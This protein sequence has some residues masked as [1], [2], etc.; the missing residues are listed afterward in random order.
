MPDQLQPP[1][2]G[3]AGP[4]NRSPLPGI[5][6]D[7]ITVDIETFGS[8]DEAHLRSD[9]VRE[10]LAALD[11]DDEEN[12][13]ALVRPLHVAD[14]ADLIEL[15]SNERRASLVRM[16]GSELDPE[17]IA[18]LD[19]TVRDE[20]LTALTPKDV[21]EAVTQL[22]T[23]DAV[24]ILEDIEDDRQKE[25]LSSLP[26][27]DRRVIEEALQYNEDSAGRI[28]QRN[29]IAVPEYWSVGQM[30]D[31]LRDN[32]D[33]TN[34]FWEIFV[35]DPQYKPVGTLK[36]S[37]VLRSPRSTLISDIM[38]SD[39][40]LISVDMDKEDVA[41]QFNKYHMMSAA[42]VGHDG[43]LVGMITGDDI[44]EIINKEAEEDILALAGV[45]E[46]ALNTSA[47]ATTKARFLWLLINLG[48]CILASL[49]ISVFE[50]A[51]TELV[52]LAVLMPIVAS[53][54]GNAGT[55]TMTVAVRALATHQ[56]TAS[57]AMRI[58]NKEVI[59]SAINGTL[60]AII[61]GIL[62][63]LWFQS[64]ELGLVIAFAMIINLLVAGFSGVLVPMALDRFKI[65]P[66]V[67]SS[68]FVTTIT[69]VVGF[70]TFLGL[71]SVW[72]L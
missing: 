7:D 71:A 43:R 64:A 41:Y 54:G 65:D 32:P 47:I 63:A 22:E 55:Q 68:V 38:E 13:Q 61:M 2:D 18:E 31:H 46:G 21:A 6:A 57:N 35:I 30:L 1:S 51:I 9:Y 49:V 17:L 48:T 70:V 37:L 67:A 69:D 45:T 25:I 56:L 26:S 20:V 60:F 42:V 27:S 52:A 5:S 15:L 28:M 24:A 19:E 40:L 29:L 3:S 10:V 11:R 8:A 59:V 58:V 14:L 12:C 16:L 4:K 50:G 34:E 44:L 72:L 39:Q 62:A 36:L 53:M 23:D 33:L 66:A